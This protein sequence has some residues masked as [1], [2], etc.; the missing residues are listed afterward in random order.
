MLCLNRSLQ[1]LLLS[2]RS[3]KG[4]CLCQAYLQWHKGSKL[5]F[6]W[7][8]SLALLWENKT[9]PHK[10]KAPQVVRKI[11]S[12]ALLSRPVCPGG[13]VGM[14]EPEW[15]LLIFLVA[16]QKLRHWELQWVVL[17]HA[18][19]PDWDE[20]KTDSRCG[21]SRMFSPINSSQNE[22]SSLKQNI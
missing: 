7:Y 19:S 3:F 12:W 17:G 5:L 13:M 15:T 16:P 1:P 22:N 18:G 11:R 10:P 2:C 14:E 4:F 9:K 20:L 8:M 6:K 21:L